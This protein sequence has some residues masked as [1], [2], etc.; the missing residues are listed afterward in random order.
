MKQALPNLK[1]ICVVR[2]DRIGDVVVTTPALKALRRA[3]PDAHI[4]VLA[5]PLTADLLIGNPYIDEVMVDDRKKRHKGW[6]GFLQLARDIRRENFDAVFILHTKRRYNLMCFIAGVPIRIGYRGSKMGWVLTHPVVD[7]RH[8]GLKHEAQYCLEVLYQF[9]IEPQGLDAFIP[10]DK[11]AEEWAKNWF[12]QQGL[13]LGTAIVIHPASSDLSRCWPIESFSK[14]VSAL[15]NRYSLPIILVGAGQ[16]VALCDRIAVEN[17]PAVRNLAGQTSMAQLASLLRRC[18][19]AISPDSGPMHIAAGVGISVIAIF[20][21]RQ[22][23][24]NPER[25]GPLGPKGHVLANS[26]EVALV[27]DQQSQVIGGQKDAITVDE[28][29]DTVESILSRDSQ[30]TFGW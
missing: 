21:R 23:G 18:R 10:T 3:Y 9:G 16:A 12:N 17:G 26:P 13:E 27:L 19:L 24:L 2:T 8:Q 5:T 4:S 29:L 28:V 1:R 25:W 14:L 30:S 7:T 15:R 6:I 11:E 20:L 22:P